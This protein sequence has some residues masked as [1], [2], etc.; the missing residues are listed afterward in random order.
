MTGSA[1]ISPNS[2]ATTAK[3]PSVWASG[4]RAKF[5]RAFAHT[6]AKQASAPQGNQGLLHVPTRL[7][8]IA[9]RLV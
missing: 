3:T 9:Q 5:L 2:S 7:R 1:P 4:Q 6:Y 8:R